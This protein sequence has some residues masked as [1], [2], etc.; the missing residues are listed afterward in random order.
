MTI[1]TDTEGNFL[2]LRP[3]IPSADQPPQGGN[4]PPSVQEGAGQ[5]QS[6][7]LEQDRAA[8]VAREGV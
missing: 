2:L 3:P 6:Q 4:P 5:S 8:G 7:T 1:R